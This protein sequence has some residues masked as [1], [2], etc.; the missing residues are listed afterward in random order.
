MM[1]KWFTNTLKFLFIY[2]FIRLSL[3]LFLKKKQ[4]I[5][6]LG[7]QSNVN[8]YKKLKKSLCLR[9]R[10]VLKKKSNVNHLKNK[11]RIHYKIKNKKQMF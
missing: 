1:G 5:T 7:K 11:E 3:L 9:E 4:N 8:S 2:L 6:K 10:F